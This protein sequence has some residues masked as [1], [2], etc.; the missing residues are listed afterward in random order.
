MKRLFLFTL[1]F[2]LLLCGCAA[3]AQT[4]AEPTEPQQTAEPEPEPAAKVEPS[5]DLDAYKSSV[6]QF[7]RDVVDCTINVSKLAAYE[8]AH[9]DASMKV[10]GSVDSEKTSEYAFSRLEEDHSISA[11]DLSAAYDNIRSEYADLIIVEIEGKE[12]EEL[13]SYVRSMYENFNDLYKAA[14][15][16]SPANY[17]SF[18]NCVADAMS[19]VSDANDSIGLFC[20]EYGG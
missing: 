7:R 19:G 6:D 2:A 16:A 14:Q 13:D 18:V 8:V 9:M 20:G 3:P 17:D 1:A 15:S 11:N 12:A 5:F 10:S 4:T